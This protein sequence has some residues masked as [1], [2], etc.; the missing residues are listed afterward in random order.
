M[1]AKSEVLLFFKTPSAKLT[2][3]MLYLH[4]QVLWWLLVVGTVCEVTITE[5]NVFCFS[6]WIFQVSYKSNWGAMQV[7][8]FGPSNGIALF[9]DLKQWWNETVQYVLL[10]ANKPLLNVEIGLNECMQCPQMLQRE[11]ERLLPSSPAK[12]I[13]YH[14]I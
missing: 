6:G 2:Y 14:F 3:D 9:L 4:L 13:E 12:K 10:K 5:L 8:R 7:F 1:G 11:R